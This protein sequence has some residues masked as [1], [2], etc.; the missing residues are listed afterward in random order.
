MALAGSPNVGKSSL[1]NALLNIDRAIVTNIPGTTRDIIQ[2]S[3]DIAGIPVILTDT[4][5]LRELIENH[6]SDYIE[7]IGINMSKSYIQ[8]AD[9]IL[10]V[11]D[12][13]QGL[14]E[15]DS[16]ILNELKDKPIVKIGSKLDLAD[17]LII[18][19]D[20]IPI[21]SKTQE[22]LEKVKKAIRKYNFFK[23]HSANAEFSTN[24]RQQECLREA[25]EPYC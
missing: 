2:E 4:A 1:F 25:K 21:S 6:S 5:G 17:K 11:Y 18:N 15:Q 20:T 8:E 12:L 14:T 23:R 22:G 10:F 3:L 7:S 19:N 13:T 24:A 9:V 16:V